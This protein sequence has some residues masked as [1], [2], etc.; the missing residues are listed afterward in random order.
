MNG[1]TVFVSNRSFDDAAF[2]AK[3]A[4]YQS[5]GSGRNKKGQFVVFARKV[6]Y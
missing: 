3:M 6:R 2:K 4:G 5:I 1:E